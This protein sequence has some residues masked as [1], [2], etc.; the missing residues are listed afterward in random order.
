MSAL[1]ASSSDFVDV[2]FTV[3]PTTLA[4]NAVLAL[5]AAWAD[6]DWIGN[7]GDQEVILIEAVAPMAANVAAVAA[8]MPAAALGQAGASLWN[9]PPYPA[10]P[11]QTTVTLTAKD[12]AGY[13]VPA[14]NQLSIDGF[15]FQ[16]IADAVIPSGVNLLAGVG[17][18]ASVAG[19]ASSGLAGLVVQNVSMPI[20]IVSATVD[21]PTADGADAETW[22][23]YL[24]RLS[25]AQRLRAKTLVTPTDY[26]LEAINW[27][28]IG[29][30]YASPNVATKVMTVTVT[31]DQ[32]DVVASGVKAALLADLTLYACANWTIVLADPTYTEV[33][34]TW[35]ATA[36]PG[37]DHTDLASRINVMLAS[38][39][40]PVSYGLLWGGTLAGRGPSRMC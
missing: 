33:S 29:R 36:F 4:L 23:V 14:G 5:Q 17:V 39:L 18:V 28:G 40:T 37:Y 1:S 9:L 21:A 2:P 10:V 20:D 32:G 11:A 22:P 24:A 16:L 12:T 38:M 26:E 6:T 35:A 7:E 13:T 19:A 3:D 25:R 27:P 8:Q 15:A 34:V 31:D 30:A